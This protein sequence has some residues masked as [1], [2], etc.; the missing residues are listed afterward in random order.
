MWSG[1]LISQPKDQISAGR[2]D[3][4]EIAKALAAGLAAFSLGWL[5]VQATAGVGSTAAIWP[6]NGVILAALV[7]RSPGRWPPF[8]AAGLTACFAASLSAGDSA[9][10][11]AGLALCNGFEILACAAVLRAWT[12]PDLDLGRTR[13]LMR[14]VAAAFLTSALSGLAATSLL[15]M[16][17]RPHDPVLTLVVWILAD[18]L[19]LM[20]VTPALLALDR[21]SLQKLLSRDR[22]S[23]TL[24]LFGLLAAMTGF[25]FLQPHLQLR[26][27]VFPMLVLIAFK[28]EVTGA[29]LG[30]LL[31]GFLAVTL[32][33]LSQG[34]RPLA[35]GEIETHAL[36][37]QV[38]LLACAA[39][40]FPVAAAIKRRRELEAALAA[41]AHDFQM[42]ADYSTDIIVRIDA[43]DRILYVSPSCRRFGYEPADLV[44]RPSYELIHPDDVAQVRELVAALFSG[45]PVDERADREQRIKSAWGAWVWMEGSPQV[46]LGPDGRPAEVIT[47]LRDVSARKAAEQALAESEARYRQ[48]ADQSMDMIIRTDIRA[49][50]QY[51]SPACRQFGYEPDEMIGR[52]VEE[53]IHPDDVKTTALRRKDVFAGRATPADIRREQRVRCKDGRWVWLEGNPTAIRNERGAPIGLITT[54]RD[55]T[56]RLTLEAQL[57]GKRVEAEAAVSAKSEFLANMSHEI[58][59]PLTGVVGFAGL[60]QGLDGLP[61]RA[62]TYV[63]RITT[64]SQALL[65]VVNDILDFSKIED[66]HIELDPHPFDPAALVAETLQLVQL[67]AEA[68]GLALRTELDA[69]LPPAIYADSARLRQILLN[70]LTNAVKFTDRGQ[71]VV[72]ADYPGDGCVLRI[73][74]EDT[75]VGIAAEHLDRLFQRF[76]QADGSI[77]RQ[78]GGT[79]LGLA[80]CR[81][82]AELMGGAVGVESVEG[83]GS[84][85]WLTIIAPPAELPAPVAESE[86][87][88][89]AAAPAKILIVDDVAADR[90]LVSVILSEFG[91]QLTEATGGA[92][93]IEA[94]IHRPFDLIL[95]DLQMPRMDGLA[96]ARAIRATSDLNRDTPIVGLSAN[97]M[98]SHLN[99]CLEAGMDDHIGKPI[100]AKDLL[101]KVDRWSARSHPPRI[102]ATG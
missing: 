86:G 23:Q 5:S 46:V 62:R 74:V 26:F 99:A 27:L 33:M 6:A 1:K 48:L 81:N 43:G 10:V 45:A 13:H 76:S 71:V 7:R 67:Q 95:M 94:A 40:S 32:S 11:A 68:K 69:A 83:Q 61:S 90:E 64:A 17:A 36:V 35:P 73:S 80:I 55:V 34:P 3:L 98:E 47:R 50:I 15:T 37:L 41:R 82:L 24:G 72:K 44:G 4:R 91:H 57:E 28:A 65:A 30:L 75:G 60:L 77:N 92:E 12:G 9:G 79:G 89:H 78:F 59:T 51:I 85:F 54:L 52:S 100:D 18:T 16:S 101:V 38:F 66:G 20:I 29:A 2:L 97:V 58:R 14:F 87:Q 19:G 63:Q 22:L 56:D 49:V 84:N 31:T 102:A 93:A 53:F 39:T 70:L 42:L 25:T 88:R 96:A 21:A 8:L